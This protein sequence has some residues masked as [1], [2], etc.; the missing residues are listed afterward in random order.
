MTILE[1]ILLFY[2]YFSNEAS[3]EESQAKFTKLNTVLNNVMFELGQLKDF[4]STYLNL[5]KNCCKNATAFQSAVR[6]EVYAALVK[7]NQTF[8]YCHI[9]TIL[10]F[11]FLYLT[12][13]CSELPAPLSLFFDIVILVLL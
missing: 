1:P 10:R 13:L 5:F 2:F 4:Q 3:N 7:V 12:L 9:I 8:L 6:E 11:F